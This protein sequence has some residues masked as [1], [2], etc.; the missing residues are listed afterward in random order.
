MGCKMCTRD[1]FGVVIEI[2]RGALLPLE[3]DRKYE[4]AHSL[5]GILHHQTWAH[6]QKFSRFW[7][8]Y[9]VNKA[10][11]SL[12]QSSRAWMNGRFDAHW[13]LGDATWPNDLEVRLA[14][15]VGQIAERRLN[16]RCLTRRM[17]STIEIVPK[18]SVS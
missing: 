1:E 4:L 16:A 7:G 15:M 12:C 9:Q 6:V 8:P 2:H 18:E 17:C 11:G 13:A 5:S 14:P 3:I 10:S